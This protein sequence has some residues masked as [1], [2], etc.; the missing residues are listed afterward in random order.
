MFKPAFSTVACP[1][2][3]LQ[4]VLDAASAWGYD[5]VELRTFGHGGGGT[6]G[7]A[8]DPG[9]TAGSKARYLAAEAGVKI[10]CASSSVSFDAPIMPPVLGR[11]LPACE[12]SVL[13]GRDAVEVGSE[14]G[15]EL[16]RVFGFR[17][18]RGG[19]RRGTMRLVV[20]RLSK[21]V[22]HARGRDVLVVLENGGD[23]ATA[24]DLLEI[25][26]RIR[27]PQLRAAYDILVAHDAG[28]NPAE[29]LAKLGNLVSLARV[30]DVD[31][32]RRPVPLGSGVLPCADFCAAASAAG[33]WLSYTW[34]VAWM[35]D[36]APAEQVLPKAIET[37]FGWAGDNNAARAGSA[38]V[39]A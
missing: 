5:G 13:A 39:A 16:V 10:A 1:D 8:S 38:V 15:A 4:R 11:L 25:M 9:L 18:P 7:F 3:T 12:A 27:F 24:D 2:W 36:L 21:V 19:T 23:F 30:R 22:D 14:C 17:I 33:C 6:D 35:R 29:G 31:A 26:S 32:N 20:E 34:D 28:E 37:M